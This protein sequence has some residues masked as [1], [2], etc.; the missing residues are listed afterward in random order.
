MSEGDDILVGRADAYASL[1][2]I[3]IAQKLGGG[4]DGIV[5]AAKN[6]ADVVGVA[7][8]IHERRDA[9]LRECAAYVRLRASRVSE[10]RGFN[11]PRLLGHDDRL[12]VLE[13]TIVTRP[14][15]LDFAD[16]WLDRLPEFPE[17][18]WTEWEEEKMEQFGPRWPEVQKILQELRRWGIFMLD[19]SPTNIAFR[20]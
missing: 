14:Y 16:A 9:Y 19:V 20:D 5:S 1:R 12:L 11:V 18:V 4:K 8:K 6:N 13:M 3:R 2:G 17:N 10:I 15:I 7:V